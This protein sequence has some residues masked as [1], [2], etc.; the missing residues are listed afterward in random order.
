MDKPLL[1]DYTKEMDLRFIILN[2][3][4]RSGKSRQLK[5]EIYKLKKLMKAMKTLF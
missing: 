4:G 1:E 2:L 5:K 3:T